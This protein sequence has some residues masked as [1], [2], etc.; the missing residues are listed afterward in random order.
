MSCVQVFSYDAV[1][2]YLL[3][4]NSCTKFNYI[5]IL[6]SKALQ[7]IFINDLEDKRPQYILTKN[8][9][10]NLSGFS[11]DLRFKTVKNFIKENYKVRE[12]ILDWNIHEIK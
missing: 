3:K 12:R 2:T 9:Y 6:S 10:K 1:L 5:Y 11:P 4:K 8:T 7:N